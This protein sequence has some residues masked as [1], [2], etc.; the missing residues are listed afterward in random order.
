[1]KKKPK[2]EKKKKKKDEEED[3][4][5]EFNIVMSTKRNEKKKEVLPN[6]SYLLESNILKP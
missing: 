5:L 1:M 2:K 6:N 3:V 4:D